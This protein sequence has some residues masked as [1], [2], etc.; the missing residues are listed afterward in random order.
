[1][2]MSSSIVKRLG[3][4]LLIVLAVGSF[5]AAWR[6]GFRSVEP[7]VA[8]PYG[9]ATVLRSGVARG[10]S[11]EPATELSA[12]ALAEVWSESL[13]RRAAMTGTQSMT[14]PAMGS[15]V[16]A[17]AEAADSAA[18][19]WELAAEALPSF[20]TLVVCPL[21][22]RETLEPWL[23]YRAGQG[24]RIGLVDCPPAPEPLKELLR[25]HHAT[26]LQFVLLVGDVPGL[27]DFHGTRV[28]THYVASEVSE[29]FGGRSRVAT[30]HWYADLD[31]DGAPELAIGRW[32]VQSP[33][34]L[35]V[36]IDKTLR[37]ETEP[38]P[39]FARRRI[40][41]VA[42]VGGFGAVEDKVL[43]GA[44]TRLLTDL[45]PRQF[46]VGMTHA[47][48]R[49]VYCP[50]PHQYHDQVF[51]SLNRG[52]LFWV[53]MGHGSYDCLDAA[54]FPDRIV[55]TI[56]T[57]NSEQITSV[58][59][60]IALLLACS[61]GQFD[62][63]QDCLAETMQ[64]S[65]QGPV[66]V[67]AGTGVTAPYGLASFGLELLTLYR[68]QEVREVGR[69]IQLA[70]RRMVE[71]A[72][73]AAVADPLSAADGV[74]YR[75]LLKQLARLF[76]PTQDMLEQEIR[77]H[78]DMMTYFGD[79]LLRFP[80]FAEIG[81]M[82]ET[83]NGQLEV[84]GTLPGDWGDEIDVAVEVVHPLDRLGFRPKSR[85]RYEA[86]DAFAARL[87]DEYQ[88]AN[89]PVVHRTVVSARGGSFWLPLA[90]LGSLP[91]RFW[92]R[93][94]AADGKSQ[95]LGYSEVDLRKSQP[96]IA[97]VAIDLASAEFV[98]RDTMTESAVT[99]VAVTQVALTQDAVTQDAVKQDAVKQDAVAGG[100]DGRAGSAQES[101]SGQALSA[102]EPQVIELYDGQTTKG[103][104]TTS[105]GGEGEVWVEDGV[106]TLEMGQVLTGITFD[107]VA[108]L[109]AADMP[110]E[111]YELR[112]R[113]KRIDG[114]DMFCGVTFPVADGYCSFVVG[115]WGGMTVGLSSVDGKDAARN[116]T[117]TVHRFEPGQ[118]YDLRVKVSAEKIE[119]WIDQQQVVD[120]PRPGHEF[121][122]RPDVRLSEP[123]G[124]FCFQTTAGFEKIQIVRPAKTQK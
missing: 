31:D 29:R 82:A 36:V 28:P 57:G 5:L 4:G 104:R 11:F 39:E 53:Y 78:A 108:S 50:G 97:S 117:R 68:D 99:Q 123:L 72:R 46:Q 70:K 42:G 120:Q 81:L 76:S 110:R 22:W 62:L 61:T 88:R 93:A 2:R 109:A 51:A 60:P 96:D 116:A 9:D 74:D 124:I 101:A 40:E 16:T 38:D 43:E 63:R 47:S 59:S 64:R 65:E 18:W 20:D 121:S 17:V 7:L 10:E 79:P 33:E 19:G 103:W 107:G 13:G 92:I 52:A 113:A 106:L 14:P 6:W 98:S 100:T 94:L 12:E 27:L 122:I 90:S 30:D 32:S 86:T 44:A 67:I 87:A 66:A 49:S 69:W 73:P 54:A 111:D 77:E 118:W 55:P 41:F 37:F 26:G 119:C 71:G 80:R 1:M 45:I 75:Q 15:A 3:W 112:I 34:Q 8:V 91:D 102:D 114:S 89:D 95:A 58:V 48:W 83:S 25:Q 115:G 23:A 35:A 56:D 105:Y 21:A 24:H 84:V 85:R